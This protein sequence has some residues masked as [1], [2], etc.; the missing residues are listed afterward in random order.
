[1]MKNSQRVKCTRFQTANEY[2]RIFQLEGIIG[3]LSLLRYKYDM[4]LAKGFYSLIVF[5]VRNVVLQY[6]SQPENYEYN[7]RSS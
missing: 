3:H 2:L 4:T 1:M 6:R 5:S 7:W